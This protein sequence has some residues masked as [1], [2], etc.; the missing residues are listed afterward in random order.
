MEAAA[1]GVGLVPAFQSIVALADETVV[2][3]EAL[4]RWPEL[5]DVGPYE[6][7]AHARANGQAERLDQ[8]CID[9]SIDRAL[10]TDLP[11]GTVLS[12]NCEPASTHKLFPRSRALFRARERFQVMFEITE[13]SLLARPHLL[14]Q[15]VAALRA[16]G[17]LIALDDVGAHPE[18]SAL[19]DVVSPDVIKL[20]LALVQSQPDHGQAQT[21]SAVLAHHERTGAVILA[22][23]IENDAHLEQALAFGADLGQGYRFGAPGEVDASAPRSQWAPRHPG[24]KH[25]QPA[26]AS[27][28]EL[29]KGHQRLR[30]ARKQ[31][32]IAFS[33]H[34]ET[35]AH[36]AADPPMV[37]A[38][39][40]QSK[41][42]T[43]STLAR[44]RG[45]AQRSPLVAVFGR[46]MREIPA[47]DIRGVALHPEDPLCSEWTV[48]SLGPHTA[49]ALIARENTD[50]VI[51]ADGDRRFDF[52]VTYD[53]GLVTAAAHNLLNRML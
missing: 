10:Q 27:P 32:V 23:G 47:P 53:R 18:S 39:L 29:I 3:F 17:F 37:L 4:A 35:Q 50:T 9:A 44:Y 19:L 6:V 26:S 42:L 40:Q 11:S 48:V 13:R 28:F 30:T 12:L 52:V 25:A 51:A 21:L 45:L 33:R 2:G 46:E 31:T 36:Q 1:R 38:A 22:E 14:L 20:D 49:A 8:L 24:R 41:Y 34:I 5:D 15:K 43:R 16:D 7:F